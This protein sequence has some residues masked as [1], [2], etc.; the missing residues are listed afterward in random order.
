M[1]VFESWSQAAGQAESDSDTLFCSNDFVTGAKW[2]VCVFWQQ[3]HIWTWINSSPPQPLSQVQKDQ[4]VCSVSSHTCRLTALRYC[5]RK[6]ILRDSGCC[7]N[8]LGRNHLSRDCRS[9]SK[10]KTVPGEMLLG[11]L[12]TWQPNWIQMLQPMHQD[13][14]QALFAPWGGRQSSSK[15]PKQ[16][17]T[18]HW[19]QILQSKF[20]FCLTLG[21]NACTWQREQ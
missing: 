15:L 8:C 17:C 14:L 5:A 12:P 3:S 21:A 7:F 11:P 20:A 9:S 6:K 10:C 16:L 2:P 1:T 19:S 4:S 18:T 13:P